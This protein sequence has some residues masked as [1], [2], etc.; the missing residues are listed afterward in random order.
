[1]PVTTYVGKL[2]G[3]E[4]TV[5]SGDLITET[6]YSCGILFA[7]PVEWR[8]NRLNDKAT[9]YCPNGH[10]QHYTGPTEADTLRAEVAKQKRATDAALDRLNAE[11][12][13]HEVT[14][15]ERRRIVKRVEAGVCIHCNRTF[16]NL[17]KHMNSAHVEPPEGGGIEQI[18]TAMLV[19]KMY[20]R[21]WGAR[22]DGSHYV[23]CGAQ[24]VPTVRA[25][26]FWRDVTCEECIK[27]MAE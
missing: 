5:Y 14:E 11:K 21:G 10:Q 16:T 13:A 18:V 24:R 3:S 15:K 26:W 17:A 6:C 25:A 1:M 9:W 8:K 23:R 12:A 19:H 20:G 4:F 7:F 27:R 22:G 2:R